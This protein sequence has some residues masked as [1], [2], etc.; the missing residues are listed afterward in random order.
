MGKST[1]SSLKRF[2]TVRCCRC[3][4]AR[5]SRRAGSGQPSFAAPAAP[6]K[7]IDPDPPRTCCRVFLFVVAQRGRQIFKVGM[8]SNVPNAVQAMQSRNMHK[9]YCPIWVKFPTRK[10]GLSAKKRIK[11]I[12]H[13]YRNKDGWYYIALRAIKEILGREFPN[14]TINYFPR[15]TLRKPSEQRLAER[16]RS[17]DTIMENILLGK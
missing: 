5:A 8:A 17:E 9:L 1:Y 15:F 6:L 11:G 13:Q 7:L 12:I 2:A 4:R 3:M 16:K 14:K 10:H